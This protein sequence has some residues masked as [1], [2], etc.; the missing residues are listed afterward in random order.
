MVLWVS[1]R[2]GSAKRSGST[3]ATGCPLLY[4]ALCTAVVS[5]HSPVIGVWGAPNWRFGVRFLGRTGAHLAPLRWESMGDSFL[6][7][8]CKLRVRSSA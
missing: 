3:S 2:E 4:P 6:N 7:A 1:L 5:R 8:R